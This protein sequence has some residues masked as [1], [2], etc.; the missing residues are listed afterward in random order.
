MA[1]CKRVLLGEQSGSVGRRGNG[2]EGLRR[3]MEMDPGEIVG[4]IA[5]SRLIGRGGA[6]FPVGEKWQTLLSAPGVD[7]YIVCNADESAP[8]TF[9]DRELLRLAAMKVIEGMTIAARTFGAAKGIIFLRGEYVNLKPGIEK[10]LKEARSNGVLG[11][12]SSGRDGFDFDISVSVNAGAYICGEETALL[13]SIEGARGEPR[14]RPPY[15]SECGLYGRP[16]LVNNAETYANIPGIIENGAAWFTGIGNEQ[17]YG[18]KLFSLS[19]HI[20]NRGVY[21]VELGKATIRDII[22]SEDFGG[23]TPSGRPVKFVH[24][25]GLSAAIGFP[26]QFY[27]PYNYGDMSLVGLSI[28]SGAI[29]VMDERVCLVEYCLKAAEFFMH[30]SCGKCIPC[31]LGTVRQH[32]ILENMVNGRAKP[33]DVSRLE[34]LIARTAELSACGL[35]QSSGEAIASGIKFR[36]EEFESHISGHCPAGCCRSGRR[37]KN[38]S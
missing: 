18:T 15:P 32:E 28:G 14:L 19:G 38:E 29:V 24:P 13:N 30:E 27:T 7:K 37:F 2:F 4:E 12:G 10:A 31:R 6:D 36:R 17:G 16:T 22:Y 35:G 9:K 1:E 23:G 21:E 34:E 11:E 25:G 8:G 33:G 20:K 26:E 3:A 5:K